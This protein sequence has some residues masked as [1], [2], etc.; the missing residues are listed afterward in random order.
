MNLHGI[1]SG[2]ISTVNPPI[3]ATFKSSNG[4]YTTNPDGTRIPAYDI[5]ENVPI[6]VQALT[7][8][9]IRHMDNLNL[10]GV[11]RAVYLNGQANGIVR[12]YGKGG[13]LLIFNGQTWLATTVLESW[14]DWTKIAVTLQLD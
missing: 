5:T 13:D 3:L 7:A 1:V 8:A 14:P 10:Q 11:L 12:K 6:Q 9:E 2:A 4:T